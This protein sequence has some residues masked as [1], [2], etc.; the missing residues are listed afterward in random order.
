MSVSFDMLTKQEQIK[1]RLRNKIE[2]CLSLF[3][4]EFT[5]EIGLPGQLQAG[6]RSPS[7]NYGAQAEGLVGRSL[8]TSFLFCTMLKYQ[9]WK[10][11]AR[12]F[13]SPYRKHVS[14]Y[15]RAQLHLP[16]NQGPHVQ[17]AVDSTQLVTAGRVGD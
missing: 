7:I 9:S 17:M 6:P 13:W 16:Q 10:T 5:H 1:V 14:S 12:F 15:Q 3:S 8:R 2:K 11:G 4:D